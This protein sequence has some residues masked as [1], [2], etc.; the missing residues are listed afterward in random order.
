MKR[1]REAFDERKA[2]TL[3]RRFSLSSSSP[4]EPTNQQ[5]SKTQPQQYFHMHRPYS[6]PH[7][8]YEYDC[9]PKMTDPLVAQPHNV[10]LTRNGYSHSHALNKIRRDLNNTLHQQ[11]LNTKAWHSNPTTRTSSRNPSR[12][13]S[14]NPSRAPSRIPSGNSI[15]TSS[16]GST[17]L[18]EILDDDVE[19]LA[20]HEV[21]SHT[22][23]IDNQSRQRKRA[24]SIGT[25]S[26][27]TF[28]N[29]HLP[30]L[31][32]PQHGAPPLPTRGRRRAHSDVS[33][34]GQYYNNGF[35]P[36]TVTLEMPTELDK[37]AIVKEFVRVAEQ[38][39]MRNLTSIRSM[40]KGVLNGTHVQI[41]VKK[42]HYREFC[43]V[44]FH[45][46]SGGDYSAYRELC[47]NFI[48]LTYL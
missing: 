2:S 24:F 17:H 21:E 10:S 37:D 22:V 29:D 35:Q 46:I 32:P 26:T 39:K 33:T 48:E 9:T 47:E 28:E 23:V 42:D 40:V 41:H 13:G 15:R 18:E 31:P 16:S 5:L 38:L 45:W 30:S 4:K 1:K 36:Q 11:D 34:I 44:T 27:E 12:H 3:P 19:D 14:R 43:H 8:P 7:E 6:P 20:F 25:E